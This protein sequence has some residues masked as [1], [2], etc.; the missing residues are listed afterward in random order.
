MIWLGVNFKKLKMQDEEEKSEIKETGG[1]S[2][3][4]FLQ[5]EESIG[6]RRESERTRF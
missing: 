6:S 5:E 2:G 1:I 3:D 4:V